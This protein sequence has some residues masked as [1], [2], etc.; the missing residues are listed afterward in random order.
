MTIFCSIAM[1]ASI[2][3]HTLAGSYFLSPV[4]LAAGFDIVLLKCKICTRYVTQSTLEKFPFAPLKTAP[5][6]SASLFIFSSFLT[7]IAQRHS[8]RI[9]MTSPSVIESLV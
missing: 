2:E 9:T 5:Y 6:F 4:F 8:H 3:V 1:L 7:A